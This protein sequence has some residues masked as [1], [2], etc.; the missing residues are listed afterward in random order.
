LPDAKPP[1]PLPPRGRYG[2]KAKGFDDIVT[3]VSTA[4]GGSQAATHYTVRR[5]PRCTARAAECAAHARAQALS[6]GLYLIVTSQYSSTTLYQVFYH[7]QSL[8]F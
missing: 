1:P 3:N 7:I 8:C 2:Q 5:R 4:V 6:V